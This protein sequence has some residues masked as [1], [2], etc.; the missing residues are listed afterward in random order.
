MKKQVLAATAF[1]AVLAFAVT[2][3]AQ[4]EEAA[5]TTENCYGV[6]KAGKNDC[7]AGAHSCAGA[8]T[9]D[10]GAEWVKVPTGLCEKLVGGSLTAPAAAEEKKAE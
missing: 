7:K 8:G 4:A 1:A 6:V 2:T 3:A 10:G 5:S 9:A